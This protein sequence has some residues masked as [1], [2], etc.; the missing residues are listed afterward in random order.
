MNN[1]LNKLIIRIS[2]FIFLLLGI[3]VVIVEYWSD[4]RSRLSQGI[5]FTLLI[6]CILL[7]LIIIFIYLNKKYNFLGTD[8]SKDK[9]RE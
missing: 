3:A 4:I 2:A 7:F 5:A 9:K 8:K 6:L 1:E